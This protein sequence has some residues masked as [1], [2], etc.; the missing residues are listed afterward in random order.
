MYSDSIVGWM[1]VN[2]LEV[3]EK[4][5]IEVPENGH[6]VEIG[7]F[8]GRSTYCFSKSSKKSVT[9]HAIDPFDFENWLDDFNKITA[10]GY[11]GPLSEIRDQ[12]NFQTFLNNTA[13]CENLIIHRGLSPMAIPNWNIGVD[14]VFIDDSH[15]YETTM[16]NIRFWWH[17]LKVGGILTGHDH[18]DVFPD[19]KRSVREFSNEIGLNSFL[20]IDSTI[21]GIRKI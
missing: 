7:S 9:V 6:I 11:D 4:L 8:L 12:L 18:N 16:K 17:H 1:P 10:Y 3:L 15:T 20:F 14:L 13:D 19:V 21:W 5:A 2:E